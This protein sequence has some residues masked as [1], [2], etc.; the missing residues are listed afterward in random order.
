MRKTL[1]KLSESSAGAKRPALR[2]KKGEFMIE[3]VIFDMDGVIADTE[4]LHASA[5]N[6]LL[7]EFGLDVEKISPTA[8]GRSKREFWSEV[9]ENYGLKNTADELTEREFELILEIAEAVE[10]PATDGLEDILK[11]LQ[12][13]GIKAAVA[14]SS[15][16]PY[17][18]KILQ[19]T[20]LEKYF[21]A[22]AC[23]NEVPKAKPA[24]DVYLRALSLCDTCAAN[25]VAVE[26]SDTGAKAAKAAHLFCVGYDAPSDEIFQQ[27]LD[28]CD[29]KIKKMRELL[30]VAEGMAAFKEKAI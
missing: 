24:P 7:A 26:D 19:I 14:S 5:R 16:R 6:A 30:P 17:V 8:I 21:C 11:T 20:G 13:N 2:D 27:K 10:L 4:P 12:K 1:K 29:V 9:A 25:A 28:L 18:D 23:G 3:A 15:D 22:K